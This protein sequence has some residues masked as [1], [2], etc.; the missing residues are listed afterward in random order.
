MCCASTEQ[1]VAG[2]CV[3]GCAGV[4]CASD[5]S[6]CCGAEQTCTDG[7][8]RAAGSACTSDTDCSPGEL[9]DGL[10]GA[11]VRVPEDATCR[12]VREPFDVT[13]ELQ[14][15]LEGHV[16]SSPVV[17]QLTDDDDDGDIDARDVPDVLAVVLTVDPADASPRLVAMS[18]DDGHVLWRST[19]EV[20]NLYGSPAAGDLDGDGHVE[21]VATL[22]GPWQ[23]GIFSHQG[24]LEHRG[25]V[26][27]QSSGY[28]I[29]DLDGDGSPEVISAARVYDAR[30]MVR[31]EMEAST[32][33]PIAAD[34]V[35]D[36]RL[37]VFTGRAAYASDGRQLWDRGPD[38]GPS[39]IAVARFPTVD[40]SRAQLVSTSSCGLELLDGASGTV[41][42]GPLPVPMG[43]TDISP[44]TI[45]DYDG[46]DRPE[47]A[48]VT[49]GGFLVVDLDI[50]APHILWQVRTEDFTAASAAST[51][52]D[53]N[54]D[55]S[56]EVIY[57]DECHLRVMRGADGALLFHA[58][59]RT[60]TLLETPVVADVDG[61]GAA[62][63]VTA[64]YQR[65]APTLDGMCL[66]RSLP[67]SP[68]TPGI[69]VYR[70]PMDRWVG[71][72]SVWNQH[73]YHVDNVVDDGSIPRREAR[74]WET[75]NTF[76]VNVP[77]GGAN[78][79]GRTP[80]LVIGA[81]DADGTR[82]PTDMTLRAR[83]EN[84]GAIGVPAG[85]AVAFYAG[86]RAS[87]GALLGVAHSST[88]LLHGT[89]EWISLEISDAPLSP[90][91]TLPFFAAADD[92][93]GGVGVIRECE[94]DD[95][96][97]GTH[98]ARCEGLL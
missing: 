93:G 46:D 54:G 43:E 56:V 95:T 88:P 31:F 33:F 22:H 69:H 4:I 11:C 94:E 19:Q 63:I 6:V 12:A 27:D 10:V 87:P 28:T 74:G 59:R 7:T 57:A 66:G 82:C 26:V 60:G 40:A 20:T 90:D 38:C 15:Q 71:A 41:L 84:R 73:G 48:L 17:I 68:T 3:A 72:R 78:S 39:G 29:A 37:E 8:C 30:A 23:L 75:H 79:A 45:A 80:D 96:A 2:A 64:S 85:V 97:A 36:E 34:L 16:F 52:F 92:R 35:G 13:A 18:G 58:P 50:P 42:R 55:G 91:G 98:E 70:D 9:C 24:E 86:T 89:A 77:T 44:P 1:C 62:E 21:I 67:W 61:D 81:L 51:A 49:T 76:R 25:T 53:L 14:W 5:D 32:T 65:L 47:I 83:L